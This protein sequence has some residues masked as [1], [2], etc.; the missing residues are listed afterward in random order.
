MYK[1]QPEDYGAFD[2]LWTR[3][4]DATRAAF[5][6]ARLQ[7]SAKRDADL[8]LAQQYLDTAI[9]SIP[10]LVWFKDCLLYTSRCV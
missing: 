1:R 8:S 5:E 9:D 4:L 2:A 10:E 7:R 3:P 6:L